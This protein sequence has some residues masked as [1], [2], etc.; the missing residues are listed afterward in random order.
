MSKQINVQA[1]EEFCLRLFRVL[2]QLGNELLPHRLGKQQAA[3]AFEKYPR[4]LLG[5]IQ[6]YDNVEAGF[7]EWATKVLRDAND[8]RKQ[9]EFPELAALR[10]WLVEHR[11]LFE[12]NRDTLNHL[13]RSLYGRV[14]AYLY[15]RRLLC[16]TYAD[17]HRGEPGALEPEVIQANFRD[18]VRSQIE[19]LRQ[20]YGDG[21]QLARIIDDAETYLLT[22]RYRFRWK[23]RAAN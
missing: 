22:N 19:E 12:D 16:T 13:K 3:Y 9:D 23:E 5:S 21:Q 10:H 8:Y 11:G 7:D 6:R 20:V 15:P 14:Y 1:V 2:D 18:E 17:L 4:L